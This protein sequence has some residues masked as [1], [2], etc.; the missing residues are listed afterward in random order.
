MRNSS[1]VLQDLN[2]EG[3]GG[4][5]EPAIPKSV[6]RLVYAVKDMEVP[7]LPR[8]LRRTPFNVAANQAET[9]LV[10]WARRFRTV[11]PET[12]LTPERLELLSVL[13][14][15]GPMPANEL[16]AAL[17]V[18]APAVT[19]MVNG[20]EESGYVRRS[21]E[22]IDGRLVVIRPTAAGRRAM[23]KGR[24]NRIRAMAIKL[25]GRSERELAQLEHGLRIL[26][27]LLK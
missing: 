16:A 13:C 15:E 14:W 10:Q 9:V 27:E 25:R 17:G 5:R 1:R 23:E 12:G 6:E 21:G 3:C 7:D 26:E 18:S 4:R 2:Y 19:R 24:A 20:L 8:P 11:E 22:I